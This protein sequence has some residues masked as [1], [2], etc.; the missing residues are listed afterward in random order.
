MGTPKHACLWEA[1][2]L[3]HDEESKLSASLNLHVSGT[4]YVAQV[5]KLSIDC[6]YNVFYFQIRILKV[7]KKN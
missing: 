1:L 5:M 2:Y 4:E 6:C 7:L 3:F